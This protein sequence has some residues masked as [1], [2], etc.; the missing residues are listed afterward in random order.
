[1]LSSIQLPL[2]STYK[3]RPA[4][5]KTL[6]VFSIF[7]F[8][9]S[10]LLAQ[11][12]PDKKGEWIQTKNENTPT[13]G[14][15]LKLGTSNVYETNFLFQRTGGL[16]YDGEEI[17]AGNQVKLRAM[18]HVFDQSGA[19]INPVISNTASGMIQQ[20]REWQWVGDLP[21]Q[22]K[23]IKVDCLGG[24]IGKISITVGAGM[25]SDSGSASISGDVSCVA[26]VHGEELCK[27]ATSPSR[28]LSASSNPSVSITTTATAS[29]EVSTSKGAQ[30]GGSYTGVNTVVSAA[31]TVVAPLTYTVTGT[32]TKNTDGV[33]VYGS[34]VS[35]SCVAVSAA[36]CNFTTGNSTAESS[37][38]LTLSLTP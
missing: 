25:A 12:N 18:V 36:G 16:E 35:I 26:N 31:S 3:A 5:K 22:N 6:L 8:F 2:T 15:A 19:G 10:A 13:P 32:A 27:V 29:G 20:R 7:A 1:M 33:K 21:I 23:D 38:T 4:V 30:V 28:A 37:I 14:G 34:L 11:I 17:V 9:Q 24:C